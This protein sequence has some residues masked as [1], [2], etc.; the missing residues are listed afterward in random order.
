MH[1]YASNQLDYVLA[2]TA[3]NFF[4]RRLQTLPFKDR[5][6]RQVVNVPSFMVQVDSHK[7]IDFS[8]TNPFGRVKQKNQKAAANKAARGDANED[9]EVHL[10]H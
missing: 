3:E 6:I 5:H 8:L 1:S 4:E 7:H 10:N 2:L 9:D